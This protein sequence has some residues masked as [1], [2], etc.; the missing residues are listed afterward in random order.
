MP[1]LDTGKSKR[2]KLNI[3]MYRH[4]LHVIVSESPFEAHNKFFSVPPRNEPFRACYFDMPN[5]HSALFLPLDV[6]PGEIAHEC[7]H[8]VQNTFREIGAGYQEDELTCYYLGWLVE[9]V[10]NFVEKAKKELD[11]S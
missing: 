4:M 3:E 1:S 2:F 9:K 10:T 5:S 7:A 11:K 6:E 8:I